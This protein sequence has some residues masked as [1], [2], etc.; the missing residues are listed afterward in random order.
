MRIKQVLLIP[1]R[2]YEPPRGYRVA[3]VTQ[4]QALRLSPLFGFATIF[5]AV[6][7]VLISRFQ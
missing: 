3:V 1:C 4:L 6:G 7:L 5:G 2:L